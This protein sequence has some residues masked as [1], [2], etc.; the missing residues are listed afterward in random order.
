MEKES[1][2][3]EFKFEMGD[4]TYFAWEKLMDS[5]VFNVD[6]FDFEDIQVACEWEERPIFME[7]V[8]KRLNQLGI[9]CSINNDSDLILSEV[10]K[11]FKS[12]LGFRCPKPVENWIKGIAVPGVTKRKNHYDLCYALEMNLLETAEF[13]CKHYLTVP[14]NYKDRTDAVYFYCLY[15]ER[16]YETIQKM[17]QNSLAFEEGNMSHKE[18]IEIREEILEIDNDEVFMDYLASNCYSEEQQY[19]VAR[20][21]ILDLL[22]NHDNTGASNLYMRITSVDYQSD[23]TLAQAKRLKNLPREFLESFPTNHTF[24]DIRNG[25]KEKY[26]TLRKTLIILYFYDYYSK[27]QKADNSPSEIKIKEWWEDFYEALNSELSECCFSMLYERHPFDRIMLFC[28]TT[29]NPLDT[30]KMINQMRY[31]DE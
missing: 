3:D 13:F 27:A 10:R 15:H 7:G 17:L 1:R 16:S 28:A 4:L 21:K 9:E 24:G 19:Q 8:V 22:N 30:F 12:K 14:F 25:K 2:I 6:D 31:S 20:A 23:V 11:R 5:R 18:T 26:E 29:E